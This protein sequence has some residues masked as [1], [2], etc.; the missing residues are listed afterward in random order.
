MKTAIGLIG[1]VLISIFA[2]L[3][4]LHNQKSEPNNQ[5]NSVPVASK[6]ELIKEKIGDFSIVEESAY[7]GG[8][9]IKALRKGDISNRPVILFFKDSTLQRLPDQYVVDSI[10]AQLSDAEK[11]NKMVSIKYQ[12]EY[13]GG[14]DKDGK[15][16]IHKNV[17][18]M[19]NELP[20]SQW[21]KSAMYPGG[22][23]K[24]QVIVIDEFDQMQYKFLSS[25]IL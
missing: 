8:T 17:F 3:F 22:V 10:K 15:D 4:Y 21:G 11:A 13:I 23:A 19:T 25:Q 24:Y 7:Q 9:I 5:T 6:E 12:E 20:E 16:V 1:V 18:L 14:Q 2:V